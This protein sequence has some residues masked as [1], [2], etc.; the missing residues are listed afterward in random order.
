M[1]G[2]VGQSLS[3]LDV[4]IG[5]AVFQRIVESAL[6]SGAFINEAR[7]ESA[8]ITPG[9]IAST[10][11]QSESVEE[12]TIPGFDAGSASLLASDKAIVNTMAKIAGMGSLVAMRAQFNKPAT[13]TSR[14][15]RLSIGD[16]L[17]LL[18]SSFWRSPHRLQPLRLPAA[19]RPLVGGRGKIASPACSATHPFAEWA[20]RRRA[21]GNA[22]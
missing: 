1:F 7:L 6:I 3:W 22:V 14:P 2:I 13:P 15:G 12:N 8:L 17:S 10:A 18:R 9:R 5:L 21:V 16:L 19:F 20:R 4:G 11:V